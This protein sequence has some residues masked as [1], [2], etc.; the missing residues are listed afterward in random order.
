MQRQPLTMDNGL[1][2]LAPMTLIPRLR[3]LLFGEAVALLITIQEL[4][5]LLGVP[6][7]LQVRELVGWLI[8]ALVCSFLPRLMTV[9]PLHILASSAKLSRIP[10]SF[11]QMYRLILRRARHINSRVFEDSSRVL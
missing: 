9:I 8:L 11:S 10:L 6:L 5:L 3:A 1:E 2:R 4:L 7:T